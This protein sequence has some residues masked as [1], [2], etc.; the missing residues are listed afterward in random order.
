ME[1][2]SELDICTDRALYVTRHRAYFLEKVIE[3]L[4]WRRQDMELHLPP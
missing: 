2:S 1:V 4:T 3:M